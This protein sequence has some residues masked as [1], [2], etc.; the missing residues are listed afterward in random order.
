MYLNFYNLRKQPFHITPDPE[1]LYLSPS[2]KEALA[3]IIYGIEEKKGF[4]AIVGAVGVGKTTILR[5]YLEKADKKRLK[6][7]YV[8]NP[9]L[10]FEGLLKTIYQELELPV[11]SNDVVEMTNRLYEVLIE[12]YRAGNTIV[13][14]VDEAQNMPVDTLENL[15]ML[16]NLETSRDKLIQIVL[17]GQP[18]FEEELQQHRLRQLR[19]RL[20]IRSTILPLTE[21][22]SMEYIRYRLEKAGVSPSAV[23]TPASLKTIVK[24]AKGIPRVMNVLCDNALITGFGY[25]RKPV[26]RGIAREIIRDFDGL[27][28]PS[29][30]RWWFPALS[31]LTVALIAMAWFLPNQE[32]VFGRIRTLASVEQN[33]ESARV[34]TIVP[35]PPA[36]TGEAQAPSAAA[37]QQ[38]APPAAENPPS[39]DARPGAGAALP[40]VVE[41]RSEAVKKSIAHGDTLIKLSRE[42][43]G[44]SDER[45]L[46]LI[47][48][49]NP[50]VVNP[51]VIHA[52]GMLTFPLLSEEGEGI[53]R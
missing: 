19:Q 16:S 52:G 35:P 38:E 24:K 25:R 39:A 11:E 47:Q 23:F 14:V 45:T 42:V 49:N 36:A 22:E 15:R 53:G 48:K 30:G 26:T 41:K 33:K 2:H 9:R 6:I 21:H 28:W 40:S 51:D 3:A 29:A 43:Y 1:F 13:L 12:E 20:A 50:Q 4:V 5:S 46:R 27:K 44:R 31:A 18:E 34:A 10:S 17:V 8:F 32:T 37:P 7:V